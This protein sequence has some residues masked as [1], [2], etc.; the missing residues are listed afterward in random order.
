MD[1]E[2]NPASVFKLNRGNKEKK[3]KG[4]RSLPKAEDR[5]TGKKS[6]YAYT[7][8]DKQLGKMKVLSTSRAWWSEPAKVYQLVAAYK[9]YATDE[10]ACYYA[11]ITIDQLQYFQDLH[12]EFYSIKHAA[13]QDPTLRAKKNIVNALESDK[14]MARWWVSVIEKNT[15]SQRME[16]A[17]PNGAELFPKVAEE[18]RELGDKI[19]TYLK[20]KNSGSTDKKHVDRPDAGH[21]DAGHDGVRDETN[22]TG[23]GSD[24]SGVPEGT[25]SVVQG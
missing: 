2:F 18:M 23:D 25:S 8:E 3:G 5:M 15:F 7:F 17:G 22:A 10:Q 14:E 20:E 4:R 6:P 11:G 13:K 1:K 12:P 16:Q 19:R 21:T 9:F 24:S